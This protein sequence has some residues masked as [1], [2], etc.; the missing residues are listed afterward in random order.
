MATPS[1]AQLESGDLLYL[2]T[3][4]GNYIWILTALASVAGFLPELV[5]V[6]ILA[7]DLYMPTQCAHK[8][9]QGECVGA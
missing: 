9:S 4:S 2:Q 7:T 1:D 8:C 3:T 5:H 6:E